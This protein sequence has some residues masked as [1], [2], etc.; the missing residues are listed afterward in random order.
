M[1]NE[2][3]Y[4]VR[5]EEI[6]DF[7]ASSMGGVMSS[8]Y[9]VER[10]LEQLDEFNEGIELMERSVRHFKLIKDSV[11]VVAVLLTVLILALCLTSIPSWYSEAMSVAVFGTAFVYLLLFAIQTAAGWSVAT[12][13]LGIKNLNMDIGVVWGKLQDFLKERDFIKEFVIEEGESL[14]LLKLESLESRF[15]FAAKRLAMDLVREERTLANLN[16]SDALYLRMFAGRV[17]DMKEALR[18]LVSIINKYNLTK[19]GV[20]FGEL[21]SAA[22]NAVEGENHQ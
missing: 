7:L 12:Y 18:E 13:S 1:K 11:P 16:R 8:H 14:R 5:E 21:M 17:V 9:D 3:T 2:L 22:Q 4:P 20:D 10:Q 15:V 19:E 6:R